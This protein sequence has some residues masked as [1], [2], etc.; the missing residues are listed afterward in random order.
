VEENLSMPAKEQFA[1]VW[2]STM[3][4]TYAAYFTSV[5]T[6]GETTALTQI[7]L[8]AATTVV[9]VLVIG[10]VSAVIAVRHKGGPQSDERDQLIDQTTVVQVLV[11]G[12]VSAVIAVRHKGG[13]QSDERDQLIDQRATRAAYQ[14]L[15]CG[16]IVVGCLMPF[17]NSGWR[18]FHAAVFSIAVSE[19]VR[20]GLM[21]SMYRR[22]A[23][24]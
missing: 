17:N 3:L 10:T 20:H 16:M 14:L 13:P 4:V 19:I 2:L 21:V 15:I 9:Q 5:F 24:G 6:I 23:N 18:I 22:G 1:W 8:F 12:T 7:G 11:I